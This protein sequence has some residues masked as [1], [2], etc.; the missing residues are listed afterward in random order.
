MGLLVLRREGEE[1]GRD[2]VVDRDGGLWRKGGK[3]V[4]ICMYVWYVHVIVLGPMVCCSSSLFESP[5][6]QS[7]RYGENSA[8]DRPKGRVEYRQIEEHGEHRY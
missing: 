1:E 8:P 2:G 6:E 3:C 5:S 7:S 4:C